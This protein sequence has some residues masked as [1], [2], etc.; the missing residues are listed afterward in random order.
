MIRYLLALTALL[1]LSNPALA[2]DQWDV[3]I[4]AGGLYKSEYPGSDE[5]EFI[6][7][8]YIDITY[9]D[10]VFLNPYQGLGVYALNEKPYKLGAAIG[11]DFGRDE[12]D[13]SRLNGLGDVDA[14]AEAVLFGSVAF[15]PFE[16]GAEIRHD[17]LEGHEGTTAEVSADFK[18]NW[19]RQTFLSLGPSLT[20]ASD[21]YMN[22][23]FGVNA[24]QAARSQFN[25]FDA[26]G[27]LSETGLGGTLV[28]MLDENWFVTGVAEYS[29]L[30]GDAADS[31]ISENDH[32]ILT[33]AFVG[34]RF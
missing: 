4:G 17:L 8:P 14:T 9:A 16:L 31:P 5:Y 26:E 15:E 13:D 28:H 24:T 29:H 19:N 20:W 12:G 18:H 32:D 3:S 10:R 2:N 21:D 34:Y 25:Q 6:P 23:Y 7:I 27:G 1:I 30:L 11:Y 22:S 33:G